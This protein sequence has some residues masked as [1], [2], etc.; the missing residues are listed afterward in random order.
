M[1]NSI[2]ISQN[3]IGRNFKNIPALQKNNTI[4]MF[5][6]GTTKLGKA[7][8]RAEFYGRVLLRKKFA[9]DIFGKN[10]SSPKH[11]FT[12]PKQVSNRSLTSL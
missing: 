9:S 11:S 12:G 5:K 2:L 1:L 3:D 8:I 10:L 4:F 7:N 6:L